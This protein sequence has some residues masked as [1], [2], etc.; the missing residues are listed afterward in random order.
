MPLGKHDFANWANI[1]ERIE[2]IAISLNRFYP[3]LSNILTLCSIDTLF[4]KH[5]QHTAFENIVGKG[6]IARNEQFLLFPQC[7]ILNQITASPFVHIFHIISLFAADFKEP[8]IG[9]SGK[10]FG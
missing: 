9:I 1:F 5:K 8:K 10:G 2:K 3:W 7:F 6:E 4:L